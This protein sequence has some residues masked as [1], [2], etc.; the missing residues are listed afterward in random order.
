MGY[1]Y[2]TGFGRSLASQFWFAKLSMHL[3]RQ[4]EIML[5][6]LAFGV[7]IVSQLIWLGAN[8]GSG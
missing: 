1:R 7:A 2:D 8:D 4:H 5:P 6:C 3:Y